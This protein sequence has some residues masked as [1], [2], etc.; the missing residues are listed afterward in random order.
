MTDED[1]HWQPASTAPALGDD[2]IHLWRIDTGEHHGQALET[3]RAVLETAQLARLARIRDPAQH[4]RAVRAQAGLRRVLGRYLGEPPQ[5]VKGANGKPYLDARQAALAFN[6]T[7]SGELALLGVRR[8]SGPRAELGV[9]CEWIRPRARL[10]AVARRMFDPATCAAVLAHPE[11]ARLVPF[12]RAW[13]ALE[14]DAKCDGRG[15]MRPRA[16]ASPLPR[17]AHCRPAPGYI[18]A[19]ASPTLPPRA[20]WRALALVDD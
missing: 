14:A 1:L 8:G 4:A 5:L 19:L 17:I 11:E 18:A 15:L 16:A 9:D 2:E 7:T 3:A 6:L 10:A 20:R 12:C 13:T